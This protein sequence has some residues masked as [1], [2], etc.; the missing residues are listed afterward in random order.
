[1]S[2]Y[3][4]KNGELYHYGVVGM[5]WGQRRAYKKQAKEELRRAQYEADKQ[6]DKDYDAMSDKLNEKYPTVGNRFKDK[7]T[8]RK[9]FEEWD[10]EFEKVATKAN[11]SYEAAERKYEEALQDP[12]YQKGIKRGR[13]IM[14]LVGGLALGSFMTFK[15]VQKVKS[16]M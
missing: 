12:A 11:R 8:K 10:K 4:I 1:M 16:F 5:K 2:D 13:K 15:T 3:I 14:G 7:E 6:F 9:Y